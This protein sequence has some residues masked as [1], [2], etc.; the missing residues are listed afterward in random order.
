M[1][2]RCQ[3][4][5]YSHDPVAKRGSISWKYDE[6]HEEACGAEAHFKVQIR[7][8]NTDEK[9]RYIWFCAK[10]YDFWCRFHQG[11]PDPTAVLKEKTGST[12]HWRT[13]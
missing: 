13:D 8:S 12:D 9:S 5:E 11:E 4:K 3:F 7:G 6:N 10:H 1:N 2:H